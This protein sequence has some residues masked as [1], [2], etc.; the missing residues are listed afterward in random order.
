MNHIS[1]DLKQFLC[2]LVVPV[3][4]GKHDIMLKSSKRKIVRN[5][6]GFQGTGVEEF[7]S[8][9]S[10]SCFKYFN[11][12]GIRIIEKNYFGIF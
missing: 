1:Y 5:I 2:Q 12:L 10:N 6:S 4:R 9:I 8:F 3:L 11:C 7:F